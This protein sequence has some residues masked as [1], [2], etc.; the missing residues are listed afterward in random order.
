M[1]ALS[2]CVSFWIRLQI[3]N[4]TASTFRSAAATARW[5]SLIEPKCSFSA[6]CNS[7]KAVR[8]S[9]RSCCF[10]AYGPLLP[11]WSTSR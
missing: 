7:A 9:T 4:M 8:V 11:S 5:I 6:A 10:I 2:A 1:A 3:S